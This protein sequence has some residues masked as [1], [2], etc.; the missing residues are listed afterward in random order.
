MDKN[1]K[2]L[3]GVGALAVVGYFIY[4]NNK[5]S[6]TKASA[7]GKTGIPIVPT[8]NRGNLPC[9]SRDVKETSL[10]G[11]TT[12]THGNDVPKIFAPDGTQIK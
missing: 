8:A 11:Y 10:S 6:D 9:G 7:I 5:K 3:L 1:T 4:Q 12:C 2:I